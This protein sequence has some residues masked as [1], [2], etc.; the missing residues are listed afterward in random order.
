MNSVFKKKKH[1][2]SRD[3]NK[4]A[5][6]CK[7]TFQLKSKLNSLPCCC[8]IFAVTSPLR[9]A[10]KSISAGPSISCQVREENPVGSGDR[11]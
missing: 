1:L 5:V 3:M 4:N 7:V 10:D 11:S 2:Q 6:V 9:D 8:S